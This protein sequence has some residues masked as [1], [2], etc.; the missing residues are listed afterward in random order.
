MGTSGI[1]REKRDGFFGG[2]DGNHLLLSK[3]KEAKVMS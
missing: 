1:E 2:R 3:A